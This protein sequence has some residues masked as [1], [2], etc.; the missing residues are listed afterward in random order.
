MITRS[1]PLS[2]RKNQT[3]REGQSARAFGPQQYTRRRTVRCKRVR[4]TQAESSGTVY[5]ECL[6]DTV[7]A[8]RAACGTKSSSLKTLGSRGGKTPDSTTGKF[9]GRTLD[10]SEGNPVDDWCSSPRVSHVHKAWLAEKRWQ[11]ERYCKN[12]PLPKKK[13]TAY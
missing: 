13:N 1:V 8:Q 5:R 11:T 12:R 7:S 2:T 10:A 3:C 6:P 9:E 4:K